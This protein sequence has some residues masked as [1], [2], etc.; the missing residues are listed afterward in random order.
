MPRQTGLPQVKYTVIF[1]STVHLFVAEVG[2]V[3]IS[4]NPR[5][6]GIRKI[7]DL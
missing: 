3:A 1:G 7:G 4:G 6:N 2:P 5:M